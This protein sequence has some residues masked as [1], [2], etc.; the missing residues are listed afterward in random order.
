MINN[1]MCVFL[2]LVEGMKLSEIMGDCEPLAS[3]WVFPTFKKVHFT[4][5]RTIFFL[6]HGA[7]GRVHL[8]SVIGRNKVVPL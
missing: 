5:K 3:L 6:Y 8:L 7:E 1:K 4:L 2:I